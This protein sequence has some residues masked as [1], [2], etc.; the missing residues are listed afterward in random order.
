MA[1]KGKGYTGKGQGKGKSLY[2]AGTS[3][4]DETEDILER[5]EKEESEQQREETLDDA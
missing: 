3:A 1:A 2:Y 5:Q 4:E